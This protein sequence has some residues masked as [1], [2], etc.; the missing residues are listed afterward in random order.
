MIKYKNRILKG[1]AIV[2]V[3]GVV[4]SFIAAGLSDGGKVGNGVIYGMIAAALCAYLMFFIAVVISDIAEKAEVVKI[5]D[6]EDP[7]QPEKFTA[8]ERKEKFIFTN[9]VYDYLKGHVE[10]SE[11]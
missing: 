10:V 4:L 2:G 1:A 7:L 6:E 3:C 9:D 5:P 8:P 11:E